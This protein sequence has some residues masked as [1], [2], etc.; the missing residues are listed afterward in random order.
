MNNATLLRKEVNIVVNGSSMLDELSQL[1][2]KLRHER[3][4]AA[5]ELTNIDEQLRAVETTM[6][7]YRKTYTPHEPAIY[8]TISS[9]LKG[10]TQLEALVHIASKSGGQ[11]RVVDAK[12]LMSE[13]GMF[14]NP[15]NVLSMLYTIINRS[16]KFEKISP[17]VYKL[18]AQEQTQFA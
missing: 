4:E 15:K 12:R 8:K 16:G 3:E 11:F 10:K 17:G 6:S 18:V 5:K 7:I 1:I 13:A 2:S 9:E 14:R